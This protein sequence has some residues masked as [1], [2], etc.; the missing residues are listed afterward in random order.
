MKKIIIATAA[1]L[2]AGISGAALAD[3]GPFQGNNTVTVTD[4]TMLSGSVTL[5]VS[6]NVHGHYICDEQYNV[7]KVGACHEGGSR[8]AAVC[9]WLP[10]LDGTVG[11]SDDVLNYSTCTVSLVGTIPP[12]QDP[13]YNAYVVGSGGGSIAGVALG[14]RC[15]ETTL[16]AVEFF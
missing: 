16:P 11:T 10:G 2:G 9:A 15:N 1:I 3:A 6:S 5:G 8:T 14:G 7:V 12:T 4:C 13:D